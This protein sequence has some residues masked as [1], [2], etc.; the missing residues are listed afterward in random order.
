MRQSD[1]FT[2][3]RKEA[4]A[5]EIAK[6][7]QLLIRGGFV[8]K[9]MAGVYSFLP[10][11]LRVLNKIAHIIRDEMNKAGGQEL[12]MSSFHPKE[13]WL[14]TGRWDSMTDLYKVADSSGREV[15]LGPTH[16]EI[17]VPIMREY[18]S[19]YKDLPRSAYQIQNKFRMELRAK[20]GILRGR[21]FIMKDLYS[22]HANQED[23]DTYYDIMTKVYQ[24]VYDRAGIGDETYLTLASGSSFS[25]YSHEFQTLTDSGEDN[26]HVCEKCKV[27]VNGEI[28]SEQST[29]PNCKGPLE[30]KKAVEVGN[31]FKLGTKYSDPFALTYKNEAGV[32]VPVIMGC[33]GIGL[34][35]LLGTIV[36]KLS[37]EKGIVWPAAVSPFDVHVVSLAK[38]GEE[39]VSGRAE[40]LIAKL[41]GAGYEVLYDDR[42]LRPGEKFADADLIGI[43]LRVVV[44][45][46]NANIDTFEVK[47]RTDD[48]AKSLSYDELLSLLPKRA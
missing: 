19:S 24:N 26:I 35:R 47:R 37:D 32:N 5:D 42:D 27:A 12:L 34:G 41:E 30:P 4:P 25:K 18:I 46:K 29:C 39:N 40:E 15:A 28:L 6:N 13:N 43:P 22:F 14:A 20:A 16:E 1:L 11:G 8:H 3:T 2:K 9:E 36:E 17:I 31:I 10:L 33:Y 48:E 45:T 7:A 23:L 21:E 38:E 44:S